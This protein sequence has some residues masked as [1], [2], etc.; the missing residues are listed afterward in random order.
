MQLAWKMNDFMLYLKICFI[1]V[2]KVLRILFRTKIISKLTNYQII[3]NRHNIFIYSKFYFLFKH[4]NPQLLFIIA[5]S[6]TY[7]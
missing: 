7:I 3:L 5:Q 6:I 1:I 2:T 4:L